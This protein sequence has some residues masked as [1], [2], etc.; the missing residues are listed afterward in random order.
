MWILYAAVGIAVALSFAA[1]YTEN[2]SGKILLSAVSFFAFLFNAFF[3]GVFLLSRYVG[4]HGFWLSCV[5]CGGVYVFFML[6]AWKP[7]KTKIRYITASLFLGSAV[8]LAA[9]FIAPAVYRSSVP[10]SREEVDLWQYR[11]F[12]NY[13]YANGIWT[14]IDSLV[15]KLN[16]ESTLKLTGELPRLDGATA[17]YPVYSSFVRA[18]LRRVR[19]KRWIT[20]C[21]VIKN[22]Q[23]R[24]SSK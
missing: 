11:P 21:S 7:F 23:E 5:L 17:L 24:V 8:L 15:A 9:I 10:V 19:R 1:C 12:G 4:I 18:A 2:K 13:Q 16:E 20:P 3:G 14:H 6:L 22:V